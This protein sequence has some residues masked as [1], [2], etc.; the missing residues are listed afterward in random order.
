MLAFLLK[1]CIEHRRKHRSL[2]AIDFYFLI[3]GH[4]FMPP[5]LVF[6]HIEKDLRKKEV[7]RNPNEYYAVFLK[8]GKVKR[9]NEHWHIYDFKTYASQMLNPKTKLHLRDSRVWHFDP[10]KRRV[11]IANS[12]AEA[13][14]PKWMTDLMKPNFN[15]NTKPKVI[16][17][18][19]H[20]SAEKKKDIQKLLEFDNLTP[21]DKKFYAAA[22]KKTMNR[23]LKGRNSFPIEKV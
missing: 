19:T 14:S 22:L 13:L 15:W 23:R 9:L 3:R 5:D 4:S 11:G 17:L 6:A 10:V 7:I 1:Y 18:E 8:F 16:N 12:Y 20:V 2:T 21:A